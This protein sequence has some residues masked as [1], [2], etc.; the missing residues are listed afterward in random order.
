MSEYNAIASCFY[1]CSALF[2]L[3]T[4]QSKILRHE[5]VNNP[6]LT[7]N[8]RTNLKTIYTVPTLT[9]H[10]A[11]SC[12]A[13]QTSVLLRNACSPS[14]PQLQC[15]DSQDTFS[16]ITAIPWPPPMQAAPIPYFWPLRR[17]SCVRCAKIRLPDA[18]SGCPRAMAPP[19]VL[20]LARSNPSS[21]STAK[22]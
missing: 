4:T 18:P 19:L 10:M 2:L 12:H 7:Q 15:D 1:Q 22:Y 21:F 14:S 13:A 9:L 5:K 6:S 20:V 17:S 8:R 11:P 3:R 16:I